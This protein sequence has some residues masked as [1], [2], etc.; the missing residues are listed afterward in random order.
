VLIRESKKN[1]KKFGPVKE[2]MVVEVRI[3][4]FF[5]EEYENEKK[6][7]EREREEQQR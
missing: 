3:P 4:S 1:D 6:E 5:K 2:K 7:R